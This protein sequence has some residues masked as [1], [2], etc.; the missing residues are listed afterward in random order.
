[1]ESTY[2]LLDEAVEYLQGQ[3]FGQPKA[4]LILGSGLGSLAESFEE[5]GVDYTD[6][7]GFPAVTVPGHSG[8]LVWGELQGVPTVAMQGRF[9]FYEGHSL[10]QIAFAVWMLRSL[11]A[12]ALVVT[13]AAGG[14][15]PR[16]SAGD[17]M[18]IS[19]HIN[20]T[21][22][23]PLIGPNPDRFGLRFPDMS[24]A[25]SSEYR[26]LAKS[27]AAELGFELQEGVYISVSGPCF[28]TPA[29][30]ESFRRLGADAVGMSTVPEVITAVHGGMKVLGI[31]CITNMAA[32]MGA[33]KLNH[34]EVIETAARVQERFCGL[35]RETVALIG[36]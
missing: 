5:F 22:D 30:I 27:A 14:I 25:Y 36:R 13:N 9:H 32:G 28:E 16:F 20:M 31:S 24:Q 18:L 19:D 26:Q 1:M 33:A 6:I 29:E 34:E 12:E 23:N 8:R 17:L 4:A 10:R 7:P 15:N 2:K 35:V 11:G 21:G 3:G